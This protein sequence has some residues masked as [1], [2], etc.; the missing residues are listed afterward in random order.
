MGELVCFTALA[1]AADFEASVSLGNR[2]IPLLPERNGSEL[3]G[4]AAVLTGENQ[5]QTVMATRYQGCYRFETTGSWGQPVFELRR[6]DRRLR[7][8]ASGRVEIRPAHVSPLPVA[9]IINSEAVSRTG[10]GT[11]YSRLTPHSR[12]STSGDYGGRRG[13]AASG[14]WGLGE[15]RGSRSPGGGTTSP[16]GDS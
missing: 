11:S 9:R 3:P 2:Q 15:S 12:G 13:L 14:L 10:P 4:N 8:T 1:P 7:E 16:G 5:P 6:G